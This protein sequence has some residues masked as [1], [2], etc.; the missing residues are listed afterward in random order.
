VALQLSI[1]GAQLRSDKPSKAWVFIWVIHNLPLELHYKKRYVIPGAIVPGP[2]KPK[3]IDSFLF[4]SL[5]HVAALQRSGLKIYD[6]SMDSYITQS[7]PVILYATAD[8]LGSAF[9]SGMVGH[10]GKFGCRLYCEMPSWNCKGDGHYYPAMH[11]PLHYMLAGSCHP[12]VKD[13]NL[14]QYRTCLSQKYTQNLKY[15]LSS[16]TQAE[17]YTWRLIMGLCK[18]TLFSGLPHQPLP[19]PNVFTMDIMHLTTLN[20]PDLLIKLFTGKLNVYEP[21]DRSTWDWAIFHCNTTLWNVHGKSV[22]LA[23]CYASLS[24]GPTWTMIMWM[25]PLMTQL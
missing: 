15:L 14:V 7:L 1:D 9:M 3:D 16:K 18:Q 23:V 6:A 17:F 8:S 19:V 2:N 10:S 11:L 13:T 25:Q 4:P 21:D 22:E 24:I 5:A 12:D 20:D